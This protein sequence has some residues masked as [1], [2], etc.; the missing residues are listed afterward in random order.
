M[1]TDISTLNVSS[2]R[3]HTEA[4]IWFLGMSKRTESGWPT[5]SRWEGDCI[6]PRGAGHG[7]RVCGYS[8]CGQGS[9]LPD[10]QVLSNH[11]HKLSPARNQEAEEPVLMLAKT[12]YS[13]I[14]LIRSV[15]KRQIYVDRK[16]VRVCL[17]L[18]WGWGV[19]AKGQ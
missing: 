10:P 4:G 13:M 19:A 7:A 17:R 12:T 18:G 15:Q 14:P 2:V 8:Q 11:K 9:Y 5:E 6:R 16:W 3:H 1:S